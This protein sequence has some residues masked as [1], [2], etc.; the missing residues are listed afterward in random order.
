MRVFGSSLVAIFCLCACDRLQPGPARP[1]FERFDT[2]ISVG[3]VPTSRLS[4]LYPRA[5]VSADVTIEVRHAQRIVYLT[6][7]NFRLLT[8]SGDSAC[9]P[10]EL[11]ATVY[12]DASDKLWT[13]VLRVARAAYPDYELRSQ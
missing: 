11:A 8:Q 5:Q 6:W 1:P 9:N 10:P 4:P 2:K 3:Y 13:E 12:P 7:T